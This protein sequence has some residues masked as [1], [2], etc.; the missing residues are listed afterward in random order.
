MN[1]FVL[2]ISQ[3]TQHAR[4]QLEV[5]TNA[6]VYS[7]FKTYSDAEFA[8]ASTKKSIRQDSGEFSEL[9]KKFNKATQEL[10][11]EEVIM[12]NIIESPDTTKAEATAKTGE[13]TPQN[14]IPIDL[15]AEGRGLA[16]AENNAEIKE[17]IAS[18]LTELITANESV[19]GYQ[20]YSN[21]KSFTMI[22]KELELLFILPHCYSVL[23]LESANFLSDRYFTFHSVMSRS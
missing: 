6:K 23:F 16:H 4:L 8:K 22:P 7:H 17:K 5:I 1:V 3:P 10:D 19:L 9:Q 18:A 15:S 21:M 13:E 2:G 12:K 11:Q 20:T 14:L